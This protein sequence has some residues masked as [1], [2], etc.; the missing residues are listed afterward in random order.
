MVT[1]YSEHS[2]PDRAEWYCPKC[3]R[4]VFAKAGT[5]IHIHMGIQGCMRCTICTG[6]VYKKGV[7]EETNETG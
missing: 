2:V 4:F 1:E 7:K 6:M 3:E 5:F